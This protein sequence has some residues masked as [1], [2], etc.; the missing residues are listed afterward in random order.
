MN[1]NK[2]SSIAN[3]PFLS[4]VVEKNVVVHLNNSHSFEQ[5]QSGVL[6][7]HTTDEV[8]D[9]ITNDPLMATDFGLLA[10]LSLW[11]ELCLWYSVSWYSFKEIRIG[12]HHWHLPDFKPYLS[13]CNWQVQLKKK[14][15]ITSLPVV[16]NVPQALKSEL[17][18]NIYCQFDLFLIF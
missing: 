17:L 15:Q 2:Y 6:P 8:Q 13:G 7:L 11:S 10:M 1:L 16:S 9:K 4:K 5:F 14:N 18:L 12:W 3:L